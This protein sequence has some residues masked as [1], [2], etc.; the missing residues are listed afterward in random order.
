MMTPQ[1]VAA[2]TF[3]KATLG[4]YNMAAVDVFLD[5]LTDD[6]TELYKE[7]AALKSKIKVLADSVSVEDSLPGLPTGF[8]LCMLMTFTLFFFLKGH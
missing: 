5:K 4:G 1:E 7:N 6:Y 2:S 3:P 8:S